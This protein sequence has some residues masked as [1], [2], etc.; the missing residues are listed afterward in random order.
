[1]QPDLGVE[2]LA[3]EAEI[4]GDVVLGEGGL[5]E[6]LIVGRPDHLL[7]LIG[8][9]LRSAQMVGVDVEEPGGSA[10][11]GAC[12]EAIAALLP[13][14]LTEV[15]GTLQRARPGPGVGRL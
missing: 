1:M 8:Q 13:L 5:T 2:V 15:S 11:G 9:D 7:G 4:E 6:G 14:T 3:G 12:G 10:W